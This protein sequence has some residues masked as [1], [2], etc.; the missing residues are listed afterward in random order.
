L[1]FYSSSG[2]R[3]AGI[4]QSISCH[5]KY[6][7]VSGNLKSF[8]FYDAFIMTENKS[9]IRLEAF[10]DGVFAIAITLLIL[11]VNLPHTEVPGSLWTRLLALWP[12]FFAFAPQLFCY[13]GHL[14]YPSR[15]HGVSR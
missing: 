14:D 12:S 9:L 6:F 1:Y 4:P 11:E 13:P 7:F 15:P 5:R 3:R 8:H 10:S 2:W